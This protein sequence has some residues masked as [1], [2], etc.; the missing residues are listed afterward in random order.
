M[1]TKLKGLT[2][3]WTTLPHPPYS[4]DLAPSDYHLFGAMKES[5]RGKHYEND[6]EAKTAVKKWL[7]E[8]SPK[9]TKLEY[10]PS[11]E[12]GTVLLKEVVTMLRSKDEIL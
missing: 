5:L 10:M 8:H 4:P 9:C 1:N 3:G 11:F 12:D 6:E 2:F 7:C